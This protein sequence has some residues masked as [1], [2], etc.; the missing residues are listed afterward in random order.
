MPEFLVERRFAGAGL[1]TEAEVAT[2]VRKAQSTYAGLGFAARWLCGFVAHDHL[3]DVVCTDD[4]DLIAEHARRC[5][6]PVD[7]I[8]ALAAIV[9]P[10]HA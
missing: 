1:L 4:P 7:R 3:Y 10:N 6:L 5:G 9:D 8:V 2:V